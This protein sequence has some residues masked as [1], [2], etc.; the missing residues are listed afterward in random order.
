MLFLNIQ[1]L[2]HL[3]SN[4]PNNYS[5][6]KFTSQAISKS[7]TSVMYRINSVSF[8][9]SFSITTEQD[10]LDIST[11]SQIHRISFQDKGRYEV[12]DLQ[13][14]LTTQLGEGWN[15]S[16]N[17]RGV[18]QI[19]GP[20]EFNIV[21][22]SHNIKI[23]LGLYHTTLPI[24]SHSKIITMPS[25]PYRSYGNVLYLTARTD[26]I[27]SVNDKDGKEESLSIAY[28]TNEILYPGFPVMCKIPSQWSIINSS[29]LNQ[30]EFTLVDFQFH[31]VKLHSPLYITLE[32]TSLT[33]DLKIEPLAYDLNG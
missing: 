22:A 6:V 16:F 12:S 8:I 18:L 26:M 2:C 30:L 10:Y 4:D 3:V 11:Q 25:V 7:N 24:Q 21:D 27:C 14:L 13:L 9:A 5:T 15:I 1:M 32:L 28:K 31:P 33:P 29:Q 23:L 20:E 17:D 19:E